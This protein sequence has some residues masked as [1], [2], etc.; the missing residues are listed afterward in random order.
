MRHYRALYS[1]IER[2]RRG[3]SPEWTTHNL[4]KLDSIPL[5]SGLVKCWRVM[6]C[7]DLLEFL[8]ALLLLT[9]LRRFVSNLPWFLLTFCR[10]L[11]AAQL[12]RILSR[13]DLFKFLLTFLLLTQ[14]STAISA[15]FLRFTAEL[16]RWGEIGFILS[17][18]LLCH[19][20]ELAFRNLHTV[21]SKLSIFLL[22]HHRFIR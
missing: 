7:I 8:L 14:H 12:W 6:S 10:W 3:I 16:S 2:H 9:Q 21:R 13:I 18:L 1:I 20:F 15:Q 19:L 11:I 5:C 4:W 22:V 17:R